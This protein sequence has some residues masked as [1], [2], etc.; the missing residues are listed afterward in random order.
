MSG[1]PLEDFGPRSWARPE[2]ISF[3]RLPLRA[4]FRDDDAVRL[5]GSWAFRLFG[6]PEDVTRQ[7]LTEP[8][9]R[10]GWSTIEVPGNWTMQGFDRPHYT[11]VQMPIP[12]PPPAV[13]DANPT[14]VHRRTVEVPAAWDGRRV[15]LYVGGAESVLYVHVDGRPIAMGKDSRL[16]SL[17]DV[18]DVVRPGRS[19]ELALTVVR[20]SDATYLEDQDHWHQAGLHRRV[21]L[22]SVPRMH[23]ADVVAVADFDPATSTG[24]LRATA[25]VDA[26]GYLERGWRLEVAIGDVTAS[27]DVHGEHETKPYV[28]V[29]LFTGRGASVELELPNVQPW[30][31]DAPVLHR[32][33][34]TLFDA[35]GNRADSVS[36]RVGFRRVEIDGHRLLVNGRRVLIKGVNRHDHDMRRG[37]AVSVETMREDIV[38]MKRHNLNAVRTSHYPNDERFYEL[39]D[40]LGLYVIDEANIE[41][42]AYLRSL[43]KDPRWTSAIVERVARMVAR[44]RNHPSVIGWSLGNESGVS[45][46]HQAAAALVRATDPTRFV[47]YESGL[48]ERLY[49]GVPRP[50]DVWREPHAESDVIAPMYPAIDELVRWATVT[51]PDRPLIMCEYA[52]AMGN[53]GG[54]LADYWEAIRAH[55]GLQGGFVWDW[56]DQALVAVDE[57][58]REYLA[59]GGDFGDEPND[60]EFCCNGVVGPDRV[61][62]PALLELAAVDAPVRIDA[63]DAAGTFRV[64]A[65][66]DSVSL[67]DFGVEWELAVDGIAVQSGTLAP[68]ALVPG[69]SDVITVPFDPPAVGDGEEAHVLVRFVR[70]NGDE[71]AWGQAKVARRQRLLPDPLS[72]ESGASRPQVRPKAIVGGTELCLWRAPT[73]NDRHARPSPAQRWADVGLADGK[74]PDGVTFESRET[75][76]ADGTFLVEHSIVI[77]DELDDLPRV[78]VRL[79]LAE[80]FDEVEWFGLG[81]HESY[82]DRCASARVGRWKVTVDEIAVPYVHPQANG[83]RHAVRWL[84]VTNPRTG[85]AIRIDAIEPT[86]FDV[87]VAHV[88]DVDLHRAAHLVDLGPRP[89]TYVW[90]DAAHR[91]VGTGAVGPD[92]LPQYRVRPGTYALAYVLRQEPDA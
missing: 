58:G 19:F 26:P 16:P 4:L 7:H 23:L 2:A 86:A 70:S 69:E 66:T 21:F 28:N 22:Y 43:T 17:V 6:R 89:E 84:R 48:T 27:A 56:V 3:G 63:L 5:D 49:E 81:P 71:V 35:A 79:V 78:G 1:F 53:S 87:T 38:L 37:K 45:P 47:H 9:D 40:E 91:G 29:G 76:L 39:C 75:A 80:G 33:F 73:D 46:A 62:H 10:D 13:P 55:D 85:H 54:S 8:S 36:F 32:V 64:T 83:N 92:T 14:G 31:A 90:L 42:H 72:V 15:L 34:V 65:E 12:G 44:D 74:T 68:L 60:R 30:F 77:P 82:N 59:Y 50:S 18:G 61:P 25:V 24:T 11:N 41:S 51:P 88:T 57:R 67:A 20:W 52:H